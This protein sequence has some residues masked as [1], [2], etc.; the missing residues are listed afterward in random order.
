MLE[1]LSSRQRAILRA[2]VLKHD[3]GLLP[4]FTELGVNPL[5]DALR[6]RVRET[7]ADELMEHGL[8][9]DGVINAFGVEVDD[10]IGILANY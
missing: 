4:I 8:D 7:L 9:E 10:I 1:R 6:E 3:P 2:A 5:S